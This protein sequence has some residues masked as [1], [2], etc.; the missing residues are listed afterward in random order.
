M[1]Q[2]YVEEPVDNGMLH[3]CV[4]YVIYKHYK[5]SPTNILNDLLHYKTHTF[6]DTITHIHSSHINISAIPTPMNQK[7][8]AT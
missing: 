5:Q 7:V 8:N 6:F 2:R 4:L 3:V 1:V